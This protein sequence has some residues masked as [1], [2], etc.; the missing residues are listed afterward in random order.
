[1]SNEYVEPVPDEAPAFY[2][3]DGSVWYYNKRM[4]YHLDRAGSLLHRCIWTKV[5]GPIPDG[6]EVNHINR[7]RWDNRL[8]NLELLTVHDHR[9]LTFR[10]RTDAKW[11]ENMSSEAASARLTTYWE[12]REAREVVCVQ[13]GAVYFSTGMRAKFCSDPCKKRHGREKNAAARALRRKGGG[14]D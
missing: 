9:S 3:W 2:T 10:Q 13:C 4:G 8:E 5:H 11:L 6:H 7:K 14:T 12:G 1:M